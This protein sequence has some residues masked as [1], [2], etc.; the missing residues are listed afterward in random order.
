MKKTLPALFLACGMAMAQNPLSTENK[1]VYDQIK[2][3][4]LRTAEKVPEEHYSFQPTPEVRTF[5]KILGHIADAQYLF[6]SSAKGDKAFAP[7]EIEKTKSSKADLQQALKDAF[8]YCDPAYSELTDVKA[9]EMVKFFGRDRSRLGVLAFNV[10]HDYEHYGNLVTYMRIKG[11]IPPS[12][13][14]R[15]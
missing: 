4:I 3:L 5:G 12:S 9:A 14:P 7:K 6:C 1:N 10:S 2:G 11:I 15:K 13:E 8:A